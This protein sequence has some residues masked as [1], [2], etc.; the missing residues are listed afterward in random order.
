[1]KKS[2][3]I[4]SLLLVSQAWSAELVHQF[5][6]PS[7]SGAGYSSHVLTIKQ[8]DRKSVV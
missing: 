4:L 1:M 6:N 2:I 3:T 5:N 7:F 8:L